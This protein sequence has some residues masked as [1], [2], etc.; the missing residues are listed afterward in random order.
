MKNVLITGGAGF[1]GFNLTK[2]L[3]DCG[4]N[5]TILDNLSKKIHPSNSR[6]DKLKDITRFII[7]D[8]CSREDW[9][10]AISNQDVII[11]L[12]AET[13]TGQSMY[14]IH[15][16][17]NINV[18][19]T[20]LMLD[21][22]TNSKNSI[23]K[24]ILSSSR[25]VYGEGMYKC[26]E[27][28]VVFPSSR[29]DEDLKDAKYDFISQHSKSKLI[30]LPTQENSHILPTSIYALTKY[31]QEQILLLAANNLNIDVAILRYQNV[32]GPGQSLSNP[33]TGIL[34]I[35]STRILNGN[36]I[37]IYE[38]GMQTRDFVYIDDVVN[39][40][41]LVLEK[42]I[43]KS[44]VYN[45]GSGKPITVLKVAQKLKE[46]YNTKTSIT[47]SNKYR[48]GDIRHNLADLSL[49]K[50]EL[51]FVNAFSFDRGLLN[52]VKWVQKQDIQDDKYDSSVQEMMQK[53]IMK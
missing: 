31:N 44:Q 32:F 6:Y 45:V 9:E 48:K 38:D 26:K 22:L 21:V 30:P 12:A 49:I 17:T 4:Y 19:G 8:V 52:F 23:K 53:G 47:I 36:D 50:Q 14:D 43:L 18:G 1:I 3:I 15:N 16:Y 39:A 5:I 10:K 40:T 13:G 25:A 27:Q 2:R 28:G 24:I 29:N 42:S 7:G 34:S 35:F 51:G 11:H 41:V 33:Y 46:L 37:E 20:A